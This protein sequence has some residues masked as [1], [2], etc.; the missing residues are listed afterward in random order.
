MQPLEP[1]MFGDFSGVQRRCRKRRSCSAQSGKEYMGLCQGRSNPKLPSAG[2]AN[3]GL[4]R[5]PS[6]IVR[7]VRISISQVGKEAVVMRVIVAF[8]GCVFAASVGAAN[9]GDP[10]DLGKID[11]RIA[12]EPVYKSK[13]PL[14]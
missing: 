1:P 4:V 11:R 3:A 2:A 5:T 13:Q 8:A 14:Y 10:P 9:A 7:G 6:S 12:K